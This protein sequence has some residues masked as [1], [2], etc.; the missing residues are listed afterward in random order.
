MTET[1]ARHHRT[2]EIVTLI[3]GSPLDPSVV[4]YRTAA[5]KEYAGFAADYI[6]CDDADADDAVVMRAEARFARH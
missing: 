2:G 1:R 5:G 3:G 4:H 6:E